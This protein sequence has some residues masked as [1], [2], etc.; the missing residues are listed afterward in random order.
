MGWVLGGFMRFRL[1]P[2]F[3]LFLF[4]QAFAAQQQATT[5]PFDNET[6]A[7]SPIETTGKVAVRETVAG[8][9]VE[10]S[11]EENVVARNI[12]N[13]PILLLIRDLDENGPHSNGGERK[14]IE[15]FFGEAI[16]PGDSIPLAESGSRRVECCINPLNEGRDAKAAFRVLFVQFLDG[17]TFGDLA[18]AG[19]VLAS[20]TAILEALRELVRVYS[21]QGEQR[22]RIQLEGR[23]VHDAS[24][25][26]SIIF[27]TGKVKGTGAAISQLRKTLAVGEEHEAM[28]GKQPRK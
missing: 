12:S 22:F 16:Q 11:W 2:S 13:K 15:N 10:S 14:I 25:I 24:E 21:E 20:R 8:N 23:S 17:S 6:A 7:G 3:C 18:V 5:V 26:L 19:D 9:E 28:I 27:T 1:L 4:S